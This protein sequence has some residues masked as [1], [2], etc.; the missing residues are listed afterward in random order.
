MNL[1]EDGGQL[2]AFTIVSVAGI[3]AVAVVLVQLFAPPTTTA[4]IVNRCVNAEAERRI[5][6]ICLKAIDTLVTKSGLTSD[7]K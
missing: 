1:P 4:D 6:P 3:I 5:S 2:M 7:K